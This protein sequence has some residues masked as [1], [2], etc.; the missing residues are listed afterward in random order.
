MA[1]PG[2]R[3]DD[4]III[5]ACLLGIYSRYDGSN[6]LHSRLAEFTGRG[7]Y[8]PVCPEQ[9]GGL[10]TPRPPVE[11]SGGDVL[12]GNGKAVN[13]NGEDVSAAFIRGAVEILAIAR[14][15]PVTAAILKERSPSCGVHEI[16]DGSF[17]GLKKAG[18]GVAV[19]LLKQ[20]KIPIYSE[21]EI[22]K[23]LLLTLL[24]TD[25]KMCAKETE[26][27]CGQSREGSL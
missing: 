22:T 16:Y 13:K 1:D 12:T 11:I 15:F 2:I 18:Q 9:L 10:P 24:A 7:Q 27:V 20:L 17:G 19:S 8:L 5:S 21:E 3:E 26:A 4:M 14:A 23:E 25:K 6:N